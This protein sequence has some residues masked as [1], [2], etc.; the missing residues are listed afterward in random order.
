[1]NFIRNTLKEIL[2]LILLFKDA[3]KKHKNLVDISDY[4]QHSKFYDPANK[5]YWQ[6]KG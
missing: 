5:N 3:D 4:P 1:M 6:N 2:V